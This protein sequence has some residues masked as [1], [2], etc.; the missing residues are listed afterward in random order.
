M[1]KRIVK[2]VLKSILFLAALVILVALLFVVI[3]V[4]RPNR[5]VVA[6]GLGIEVW[7]AVADGKH[8]SN[9][10][11]VF[12]KDAFWLIHASAPWHFASETTRLVLWK[13]PDARTWER[14]AGV[15]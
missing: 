2:I 12:F 1:P 11:L 9:T 13:S 6:E 7:P 10:D 5:S 14:V 4:A 3:S 15:Q 8:N